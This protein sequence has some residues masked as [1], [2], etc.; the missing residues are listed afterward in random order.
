[1]FEMIAVRYC[2]KT[3]NTQ[4][5]ADVIAKKVGTVAQSINEPIIEDVDFLFLGG[6][7][8]MVTLDN[9]LK[10]YITH[11]NKDKIKHVVMFGTS[12]SILSIR[13]GLEKALHEKQLPIIKEHLFLHGLKPHVNELTTKQ[14]QKIITFVDTILAS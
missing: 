12:G 2:S 1:M 6:A 5:V 13:K 14:V 3:G 10:E 8:H 4:K 11:L 9:E 7:V